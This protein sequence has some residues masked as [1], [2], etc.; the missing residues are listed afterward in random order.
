[1]ELEVR[2]DINKSNTATRFR[3]ALASAAA[4][5]SLLCYA[6]VLLITPACN[7]EIAA[8][9][10]LSLGRLGQLSLATMLGFF[11]TVIPA[12]F[13]SDR[14]GK[15]PL[16]SLGCASMAVGAAAFVLTHDFRWLIVGSALFGIGGGFSE[17]TSMALLADV[18]EGPRRSAVMNLAQAMFGIGAVVAPLGI[19]WILRAGANWRTGYL[20]AAAFCSLGLLLNVL[21]LAL[22]REARLHNADDKP[23]ALSIVSDGT[24]W[25][26]A[27][28][29]FLYVGAEIGQS[30]WL[31][32]YF[33]R[34]L[35]A[36]S[37][38]AASSPSFMWL[39]IGVGRLLAACILHRVSEVPF[40]RVVLI[41]A[42]ISQAALIVL[43][44]PLS[45][46]AAAFALG[47]FLGPV[48]P[49]IVSRANSAYPEATGSVSSVV[50][51]AGSLGAAVFPPLIGLS[52]DYLGLAKA[53]WICFIL[54]FLDFLVVSAAARG[55]EVTKARV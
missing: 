48:F 6:L 38:L 12:G 20:G 14:W 32:V 30:T 33:K 41:S 1:M 49:T 19:G 29:I 55:S 11:A 5:A 21:A 42:A 4:F 47:V 34:C 25:L 15:L 18:Y 45:G 31:S 44:T 50:M 27:V 37:S 53:L 9:Y 16:M 2:T 28:A 23:L 7:N 43:K 39:G 54:L 3:P 24:V 22:H 36:G 26:L 40:V 8:E 51:A 17:A 46:A 13:L 10:Q 35:G 52:A